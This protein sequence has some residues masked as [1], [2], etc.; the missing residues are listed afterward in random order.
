MLGEVR[1]LV[2]SCTLRLLARLS[3]SFGG[4]LSALGGMS[5]GPQ[6]Q[7]TVFLKYIGPFDEINDVCPGFFPR[8]R[9]DRLGGICTSLTVNCGHIRFEFSYSWL[10]WLFIDTGIATTSKQ[11]SRLSCESGWPLACKRE[12]VRQFGDRIR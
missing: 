6:I 11:H 12:L 2:A 9:L 10:I 4:S 3:S 8:S 7:I 1:E 5:L